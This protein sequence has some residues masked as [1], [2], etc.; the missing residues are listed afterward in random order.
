MARQTKRAP[1]ARS[2]NAPGRKL[3]LAGLGAVSVAR[4]R[5]EAAVDT[6]VERSTGLRNEAGRLAKTFRRDLDR[7]RA[8]VEKQVQGYVRPI[9]KRA[10]RVASKLERR[11]SERVGVVLGR[12]GV[13]SRADILELT[14]RVDALNRRIRAGA[15]RHAAA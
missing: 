1:R 15:R 6:V 9:R 2:K 14:E 11:V 5:G 12:F 7:A 8:D 10:E 3:W 13:P 4:K